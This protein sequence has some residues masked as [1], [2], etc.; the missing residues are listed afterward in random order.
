MSAYIPVAL[1]RQIRQQFGDRCAYC[2]SC[3]ALMAVTFEIE[4]IV[5]QS[6]G[7]EAVPENLCLACPPCNRSKANRQSAIDPETGETI[8]FFHPQRDRWTDHFEWNQTFT[9][10]IPRSAIGKITIASL[11]MNRVQLVNA[12]ELWVEVD[13]HP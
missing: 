3:E 13:R 8:R 12:R 11:Q 1:Q 7:G 9:E 2:Q 4:H 10:L 5:P 6:A